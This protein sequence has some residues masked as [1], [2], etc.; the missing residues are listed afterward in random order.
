MADRPLLEQLPPG[1][2]ED[3]CA[4]VECRA[5]S[6]VIANG[7][8]DWVDIPSN[9]RGMLGGASRPEL[10][11]TPGQAPASAVLRIKVGWVSATLAAT[12]R[13]GMLAIDTSKLPFLAPRSIAVEIQRFVDELNTRLAAN[14]KALGEPSFGPDGMTLTKVS[15]A[16]GA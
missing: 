4:F 14:A 7:P 16:S 10:T 12:V 8:V 2:P 9:V 3:L 15:V 11:V 6:A 1:V 5:D 13:D